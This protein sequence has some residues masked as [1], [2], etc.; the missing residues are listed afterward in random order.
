MYVKAKELSP[1]KISSL[2]DL[3]STSSVDF[4]SIANKPI[5]VTENHHIQIRR[6]KGR[7]KQFGTLQ[8][9]ANREYFVS[10]IFHAINFCVK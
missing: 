10:Q 7:M 9:T 2:R 4:L 5:N 8:I 6:Y 1:S 3:T